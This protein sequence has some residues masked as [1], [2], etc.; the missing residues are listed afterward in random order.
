MIYPVFLLDH[1]KGKKVGV[2]SKSIDGDD[3]EQGDGWKQWISNYP[4]CSYN[5]FKG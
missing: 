4:E 3:G 2:W 1:K 5:H